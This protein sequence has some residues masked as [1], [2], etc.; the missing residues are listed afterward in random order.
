[1]EAAQAIRVLKQDAFGRVERVESLESVGRVLVRRVASGSRVPGSRIVARWMMARERRALQRLHGLAGVP[2][3][4]EPCTSAP[5]SSSCGT[6]VRTWIDGAPLSE[7]RALPEDFFDNLDALVAALHA[8]GVCHNDLHK[9]QNVL[10]G[11]DGWPWLVD[12]QLASV[13][14]RATR[15]FATRVRDDLRH[16]EKHRRRY[17]RRGRGPSGREQAGTGAGLKRSALALVWRRLGKPLYVVITRGLLDT[18]DG[19]ARRDSNG[20]WPT[21]TP[22]IG[23]RR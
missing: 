13:H 16:I 9:E 7:A 15:T 10:V 3:L 22:P 20:P 4:E 18:R 11:A 17:T 8:R 12:F 2:Q 23:P 5:D 1:M 6:L 14:A 19:E 21:W